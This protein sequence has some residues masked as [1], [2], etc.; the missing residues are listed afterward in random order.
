[1][2]TLVQ[3]LINGLVLGSMYALVALGFVI[4]YKSSS[5]LNFA[6]TVL[7]VPR[8]VALRKVDLTLRDFRFDGL[9]D[10]CSRAPHGFTAACAL[11]RFPSPN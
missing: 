2:D 11:T 1:M 5:I 7:S 3:Q 9:H 4:I 6:P 10:R 8:G